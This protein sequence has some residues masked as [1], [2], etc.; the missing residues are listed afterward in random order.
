L[1]ETMSNIPRPAHVLTRSTIFAAALATSLGASRA[2]EAQEQCGETECPKGYTCETST[3]GCPLIACMEGDECKP[4]E[5]AEYSWCAPAP[6]ETDADCGAHMKC[7]A[8]EQMDCGG[9][10]EPAVEPCAA[11]GECKVAAPDAPVE[12]TST[13]LHQCQ[14]QWTLPCETAA[15]C[16]EGF[17]CKERESCWCS[18]S[19]GS[20]GSG[21][22]G[23]TGTAGASSGGAAAV[24]LPLPAEDRDIGTGTDEE[25][26]A[27]EG[28]VA[29]APPP[30]EQCGCEP[31]GEFACEVV[32]TACAHDSDCPADW[33]CEDNP[34]GSC[35]IDSEGNSGCTPADPAKL[36]QPPYSR[37]GGGGGYAQ[38]TGGSTG[39]TD[40]ALDDSGSEAPKAAGPGT[41]GS[42]A[43]GDSGHADA[44]PAD[45][46]EQVGAAEADASS[47][48]NVAG[49][50]CSVSSSA[51]HSGQLG[52]M[53][54]AAMAALGLR[55]RSA[56]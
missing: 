45:A 43:S 48:S 16:G 15:D 52:L 39:T 37:L 9:A 1:E 5:P 34:M 10:T 12:C 8:I 22:G 44:V 20:V 41:N 46:D 2:A 7:A 38:T 30:D 50:G 3:L 6:C 33:T 27:P 26:A 19:T 32:E 28:D 56:R 11:D 17:A 40:I 47:D 18:G 31:S 53:L 21:V 4:C 35:W 14:P 55:R 49:G 24:D 25:G 23:S 29:E 13:T 54:A 36:C 51:G 42:A